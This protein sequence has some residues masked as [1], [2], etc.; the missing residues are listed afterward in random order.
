MGQYAVTTLS[1]EQ[2]EDMVLKKEWYSYVR[3]K[4]HA[5]GRFPDIYDKLGGI[6]KK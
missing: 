3:K 6:T 1:R 2:F 5:E 4:Y